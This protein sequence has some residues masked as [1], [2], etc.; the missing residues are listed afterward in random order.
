M[1]LNHFTICLKLT[2]NCKLTVLQL[3]KGLRH[4]QAFQ[5]RTLSSPPS[6]DTVLVTRSHHLLP[7]LEQQCL[8]DAELARTIQMSSF[9]F[10]LTSTLN[11]LPSYLP[12]P[13]SFLQ[14]SAHMSL[15][16]G[17][18]PWLRCFCRMPPYTSNFPIRF[19]NLTTYLPA[20][21]TVR[22]ERAEPRLSL[23]SHTHN[24]CT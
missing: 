18:L 14:V 10:S 23:I 7:D 20:Y 12:L 5:A 17:S 3:K 21:Q 15:P 2:Q 16:P 13:P 4:S 22:C 8:K 1:Y 19:S 24:G 11:T 9:P 6:I